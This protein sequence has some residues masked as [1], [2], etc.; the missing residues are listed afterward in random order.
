MRDI[1]QKNRRPFWYKPL[2]AL[3]F[4]L[5][6]FQ[7]ASCTSNND[8]FVNS[9]SFIS[10]KSGKPQ[11][12]VMRDD[13]TNQIRL[14]YIGNLM[15]SVDLIGMFAHDWSPDGK[16]LAFLCIRYGCRHKSGCLSNECRWL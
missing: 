16:Y 13:G 5:I 15:S 9:L 4:I 8:N 10:D 7:A 2:L 1:E 3:A 14:T 11:I 12:Y 6:V